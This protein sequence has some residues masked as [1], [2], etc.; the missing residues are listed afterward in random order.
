MS[1]DGSNPQKLLDGIMN[2]D[3]TDIDCG[4]EYCHHCSFNQTCIDGTRDCLSGIC[5]SN[6]RCTAPTAAPSA[7]PAES[8]VHER[9][10]CMIHINEHT[11]TY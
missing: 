10:I 1:K 8:R 6:N 3:E 11:P 2:E 4:G 9:S 5:D 7:A